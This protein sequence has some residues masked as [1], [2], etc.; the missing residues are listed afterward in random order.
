MC[1]GVPH[2]V[3]EITG[4]EEVLVKVGSGV[5]HCFTGLLESVSVGDWVV[6]HAGLAVEK[7]TEADALENLQLIHTYMT[8]EEAPAGS[9]AATP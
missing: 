7:I 6:V 9:E 3:L 8:G 5:Q 4:E 2:K 1:L